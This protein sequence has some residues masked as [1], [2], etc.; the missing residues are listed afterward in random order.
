M[1][2]SE[3]GDS[4]STGTGRARPISMDE[5]GVYGDMIPEEA[6]ED[7]KEKVEK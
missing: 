1:N 4:G 3:A 2:M 5:D 7:G 6:I